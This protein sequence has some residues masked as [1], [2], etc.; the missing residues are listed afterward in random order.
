VKLFGLIQELSK[1]ILRS[2]T[3]TV[4]IEPASQ[5]TGNATITIPD[6]A[7]VSQSAVLTTQTQT[8][9]NKTLTTPVISTISNTGTLTLPTSTDTLVGRATTDTLTN[10][11]IDGDNNTVQ[12]LPITSIKTVL[13]DASK[14]LVRDASGIPTSDKAVPTGTVVG[15]SDSQTLTN[16]T[17]DA[18]NNTI[19]NIENADIKAG[20]AIARDKLASG[21]ADHVII[22]NGSGVL[23]SEASLAISRGG[24]G[25]SSQTA[26]FDALAPTT[27]KGDSIVYNGSDN[28]RF[29]VGTDGQVLTADSGTATGLNW[30]SPLTNPMDSA[31][32]IIIGGLAGAATKLDHPGA[33]GSVL[34]TTGASTTAWSTGPSLTTVTTS[35]LASLGSAKITGLTTGVLHADADGDVTSSNVINADVDAAAAID[36]SK[37]A[38]LTAGNV[39]LGNVSNVATSTALSGDVTVNSS[40]VTAIA[41]GVIVNGDVSGSAAIDGTKISPNFGSQDIVTTGSLT[42]DTDTFYVNKTANTVNVGTLGG[43]TGT[44]DRKL[45]VS[46]TTSSL[47][48]VHEFAT[49]ATGAYL[50]TFKARGTEATPTIVASGD[51]AGRVQHWAYDGAAYRRLAGQVAEVD[52]TPGA[53]DMPGRLI[54]L[55]TADGASDWTE[56]MRITN[57]GNVGIGVTPTE[58]FH[59]RKNQNA[60]TGGLVENTDTT[61]TSSRAR[62]RVTG[63]TVIG[64]TTSIAGDGVYIGSSSSH[65]VYLMTNGSERGKI[66]TSANWTLG[67]SSSTS[68]THNVYGTTQIW[69]NAGSGA[70]TVTGDSISGDASAVAVLSRSGTNN[71]SEVYISFRDGGTSSSVGTQR[72]TLRTNAG[73]TAMEFTAISDA[74]LKQNVQTITNGLDKITAIRPVTFEWKATGQG[75]PG[76]IAQE[77]AQVFPA[78]VSIDGPEETHNYY[79]GTGDILPYLIAAVKELKEKNDALEARV[80]SLEGA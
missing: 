16:K 57:A 26:A 41:S 33:A 50:E 11:T 54:F 77:F 37:L 75:G 59:V 78:S 7:G 29:A 61:N 65:T 66:D 12:D 60:T 76:F 36:F 8:L 25:Q 2:N 42:V 32:D 20:A 48:A 80:V 56:R 30:S 79:M 18:D 43:L 31:G 51:S 19:S 21:T 63:G 52:G 70:L 24:T 64:E 38:T 45:V 74:R 28:V 1:L 44:T 47:F 23:T 10:K 71:G 35:G 67:V 22:N 68:P 5:T 27:T 17:I 39:V 49:D 73:N 6:L 62:M 55:T 13:A 72:S 3:R 53:S 14:F 46:G 4:T 58:F 9:T 15:N 69:S 40:G 34:A